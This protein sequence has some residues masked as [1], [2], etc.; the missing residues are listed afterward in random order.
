MVAHRQHAELALQQTRPDGVRRACSETEMLDLR[1][2]TYS[3]H[4]T[5]CS[6]QKAES[7]VDSKQAKTTPRRVAQLGK[8]F[9]APWLSRVGYVAEP[10]IGEQMDWLTCFDG[11]GSTCTTCS[12]GLYSS[13]NQ[14]PTSQLRSTG[15]SRSCSP[16]VLRRLGTLSSSIVAGRWLF[17]GDGIA[18]RSPSSRRP[19]PR[20]T[21]LLLG[22]A[23]AGS[24]R[25]VLENIPV[26]VRRIDPCTPVLVGHEYAAARRL[27]YGL[28]R[29]LTDRCSACDFRIGP[30][31][32]GGS[33]C[34]CVRYTPDSP[35]RKQDFPHS[36]LHNWTS[37]APINGR[38][39][40]RAT[41]PCRC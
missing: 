40:F 23:A 31:M 33:A 5:R 22:Q 30:C 16:G 32:F 7:F 27:V 17:F 19:R 34:A 10:V 39:S 38:T 36:R 29:G 4:K 11:S 25:R 21:S 35:L 24:A 18:P 20:P 37:A 8:P 15:I 9:S 12:L 2:A 41:M 13:R 3:Y 14:S 28:H 26:G 1:S 6:W